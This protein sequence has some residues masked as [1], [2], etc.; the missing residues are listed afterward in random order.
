MEVSDKLSQRFVHETQEQAPPD[1]PNAPV[2]GRWYMVKG[3]RKDDD[4]KPT[5]D[6][7][8]ADYEPS[9]LGCVIHV[10]SNYAEVEGIRFTRRVHFD[11]LEKILTPV[12]DPEPI[13]QGEITAATTKVRELM[14]DVK[15]VAYKL[16]VA[17]TAS[18]NETQAIAVRGQGDE[19]KAYKRALIKAQDKELPQ[20]FAAIKQEQEKLANWLK[21][22][23]I[24]LKAQSDALEPAMEAIKD[25]IFSVELYA[26]LCEETKQIKDG[27]P[28]DIGE[29]IHLL[30]R[31][32]YM[33]EECLANYEAGG[34]DF[35]SI[36]DFGK[37][38][39]RKDNF[40]RI[41]PHP[42]CVAAFQVRRSRK[43][44]SDEMLSIDD[45]FRIREEEKADKWTFLYIRNGGQLFCLSTEVEFEQK[46]FPDI[47]RSRF[48]GKL[49]AKM[50]GSHVSTYGE[51][52]ITETRYKE[53]QEDEAKE[54]AEFKLKLKAAPKKNHWHMHEPSRESLDYVLFDDST[55]YHDDIAAYVKGE[56]DK[57]NRLVLVLQGLLDRSVCLHPHPPYQLWKPD[58]FHN[59]LKLVYD[60]DRA[61]HD[62]DKPDF[63]AYR[64]RLN[65]QL[66][67]GS[68]TV[69][70]EEAW[71]RAEAVKE[72][73]RRERDWR[74]YDR[75]DRDLVRY[76]PPGNS[77]PG[78]LAKVDSLRGGKPSYTWKRKSK[79]GEKY[80]EPNPKNP[81]YG[82]N[83]KRYPIVDAS[84]S[85]SL[86]KILNVDAYT[87]GDFKIFFNDPR[88][89]QEYLKWA[90][91][92][93]VAEDYKAGK[94]KLRSE[95]D[96]EKD[97]DE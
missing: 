69:G 20:L 67:V 60:F 18:P 76:K 3:N 75:H 14:E 79:K 34:M 44:R 4:E 97:E 2:V 86:G 89:R 23:L 91:L 26:G 40:E 55:V 51:S 10:G 72:N 30:Q 49:Y 42:R 56:V 58:D 92:L 82:W 96:L 11:H 71:L 22:R 9:W 27:T 41:L 29:P 35:K 80:W 95:K 43:D 7:S 93:L 88:T 78:Q 8:K 39:G 19:I 63:E 52:I 90:P 57:H 85:C 73:A 84:F 13:I 5:D 45:F 48:D 77:G 36:A 46:L 25:R 47:S 68:V 50:H 83:R 17:P 54:L 15:R 94:R 66:L 31:R 65:S 64:A 61:L 62:G 74:R 70:Q 16:G 24:P 1:D 53:M 32:Y 12:D 81:G 37:W 33:D 38:L 6:E 87:P 28:A 59:A 21:A